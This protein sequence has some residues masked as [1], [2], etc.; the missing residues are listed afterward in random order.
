[1]ILVGIPWFNWF[2]TKRTDLGCRATAKRKRPIPKLSAEPHK[3][4]NRFAPDDSH[5]Y[6]WRSARA[7]LCH[8]RRRN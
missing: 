5:G 8:S 7:I 2:E 6:E 3:G 4:T 1:M